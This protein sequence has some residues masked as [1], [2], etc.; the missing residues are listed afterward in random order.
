MKKQIITTFASIVF[1]A[2]SMSALAY[3]PSDTTGLTQDEAALL[4]G[5]PP[6]WTDVFTGDFNYEKHDQLTRAFIK[7]RR[8]RKEADD[9]AATERKAEVDA[10]KK[11]VV[12]LTSTIKKNG[13]AIKNLGISITTINAD[14]AEIEGGG[15]K[16][17][18]IAIPDVH[19]EAGSAKLDKNTQHAFRLLGKQIEVGNWIQGFIFGFASEDGGEI[20]NFKL[21]KERAEAVWRCIVGDDM[22]MAMTFLVKTMGETEQFGKKRTENRVVKIKVQIRGFAK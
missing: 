5:A 4:I 7:E 8:A 16:E 11:A 10:R 13:Q 20:A 6:F 21:A 12:N 14:L 15:Y 9:I 1:I 3:D 17:V 18:N 2:F 22:K 19:F